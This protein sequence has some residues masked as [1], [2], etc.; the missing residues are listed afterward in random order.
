MMMYHYDMSSDM[1]S[2]L[3]WANIFF[4]II[5][6]FE[7]LLKIIAL[8][9]KFY[10]AEPWNVFDFIVVVISIVFVGWDTD[11]INPT[12]LRVLR[13]ARLFRLVKVSKG[14]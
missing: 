3:F 12:L 11:L 1:K 8:F 2:T 7:F 4:I 10:F 14:L 13:I 9:P 6:V 5:F